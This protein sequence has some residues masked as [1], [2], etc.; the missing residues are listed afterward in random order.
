MAESNDGLLTQNAR[1]GLNRLIGGCLVVFLLAALVI[2]AWIGWPYV[3]PMLVSKPAVATS[4]PVAQAT[5]AQTVKPTTA[6]NVA[7]TKIPEI[8]KPTQSNLPVVK[9]LVSNFAPYLIPVMGDQFG[10]FTK[11]GIRVEFVYM[12]MDGQNKLTE[13]EQADWMR[14][15]KANVL[16][17][18]LD[19]VPSDSTIGRVTFLMNQ[20]IGADKLV[21]SQKLSLNDIVG[22]KIAV[23]TGS[24]DEVFVLYILNLMQVDPAKVT[25]VQ[26]G[27]ITEAV[28]L[29]LD[30]KVDCVS[31][32]TPDIEPALAK[33]AE[34]INSKTVRFPVDVMVFSPDSVNRQVVM[35]AYMDGYAE[36]LKILMENPDMAEEAVLKFGHSDWTYVEKKGDWIAALNDV[37][38]ASLVDNETHF[39]SDNK[40]LKDRLNEVLDILAWSG[41]SPKEK[42]DPAQMFD[43]TYVKNSATKADLRPKSASDKLNFDFLLTSKSQAPKLKAA[44]LGA[45]VTTLAVL[46]FKD[47]KFQPDST[48]LTDADKANIKK[49]V[50]PV[51]LSSDTIYLK[52]TGSAAWP[53][54]NYTADDIQSFALARA[55]AVQKFLTSP[56]V[57]VHPSRIIVA[58][59]RPVAVMS[60][61]DQAKARFVQF[62]LIVEGR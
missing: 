14:S 34:I 50:A 26:A 48:L 61:V 9:V 24:V 49:F 44:D 22:K 39:V 23:V 41:R 46:P 40:P 36:S 11:R 8:L 37:A 38:L 35:Q 62:E 10:V 6:P 57:G 4:A 47:V 29:F 52:L 25:L 16:M 31:G 33:G 12:G 28:Q 60:A 55:Q 51:L 13:K 27:D 17:T 19:K 58:A 45:N 5:A 2:G 20:T 42:V 56:E 18:T 15:N 43:A 7:P 30:G 59:V 53:N 3:A 1:R 21:C 32:W 54:N